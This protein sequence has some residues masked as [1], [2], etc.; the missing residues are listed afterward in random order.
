IGNQQFVFVATEKP[1]EFLLREVRLG[2]ESNGVYPVL[3]GLNAGERVVTEGSFLLR[4]EW[5]KEHPV[6]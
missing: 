2:T 1:N 6:R 4:A 3:E 5:L